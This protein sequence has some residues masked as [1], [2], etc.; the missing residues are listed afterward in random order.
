M[1]YK[2][3][4]SLP[5]LAGA[6]PSPPLRSRSTSDRDGAC[7][8]LAGARLRCHAMRRSRNH[9]RNGARLYRRKQFCGEPVAYVQG[10]IQRWRPRFTAR[11]AR[12]ARRECTDRNGARLLSAGT[13]WRLPPAS[14]WQP[15]RNGARLLSAGSTV[16]LGAAPLSDV[17][18][19]WS[20]R[21]IGGNTRVGEAIEVPVRDTAM[22][23]AFYRREYPRTRR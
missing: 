8:S 9:D 5:L 22:E 10:A 15:N 6:R 2:P 17:E 18:P 13:P 21:F 11:R 1:G 14:S 7:L 16:D 20:P 12:P 23:P 19:Q 4:W 3:R